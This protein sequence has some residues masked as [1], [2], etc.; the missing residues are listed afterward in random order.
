MTLAELKA[1][2]KAGQITKEQYLAK[3]AEL[4]QAGTIT[5]AENDEAVKYEPEKDDP[6]GLTPEQRKAVNKAVEDQ[7]EERLNR[8]KVSIYKQLG[9]KDAK[10]GKAL[11]DAARDNKGADAA[12][13]A[14]VDLLRA[15]NK[16]LKVQAAVLKSP[17]M[18]GAHDPELVYMK[19]KGK[20]QF[21]PDTGEI[22]GLKKTLESVKAESPYLFKTEEGGTDDKGNPLKGK[23]PGGGNPPKGN[24]DQVEAQVKK[25]LE[26]M[27]AHVPG[28][29]L[30]GDK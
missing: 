10:E 28:L 19:V 7:I 2:F 5:Q 3:L 26:M 4:L 22:T 11:I 12:T 9:I 16:E 13:K 27:Q 30:T 25:N 18:A 20:L 14:E 24:P 17:L 8:Q 6:D 23:P 1:K 21:D 15:E 29:K